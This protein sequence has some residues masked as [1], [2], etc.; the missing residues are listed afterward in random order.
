MVLLSLTAVF[1]ID[2]D[3]IR[4]IPENIF[5]NNWDD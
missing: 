3:C 1:D 4:N 5:R 2:S